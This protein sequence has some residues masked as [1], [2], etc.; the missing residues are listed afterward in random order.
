MMSIDERAEQ[1][2]NEYLEHYG[3]KGM[4]WGV[5]KK[6]RIPS[7]T[8][9]STE[10]TI[11]KIT[12]ND[13]KG[14]NEKKLK[15]ILESL[16]NS[17]VPSFIS[18]NIKKYA[19]DGYYISGKFVDGN[20]EFID[21]SGNVKY[22]QVGADKVNEIKEINK[23]ASESLVSKYDSQSKK[24]ETNRIPSFEGDSVID[25]IKK[26]AELPL[27]LWPEAI[28][29][30][31]LSHSDIN[32]LEDYI[33]HFG[34]L[35]MKWGVKHGPPY[36]LDIKTSKAIK[37]SG[38][39]TINV[40]DLTDEDLRRIINRLQMERQLKDLT[41]EDVKKAE[42]YA[43][44]SL[45]K[46]RDKMTD[47]VFDIAANSLKTITTYALNKKLKQDVGTSKKDKSK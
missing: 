14:S 24:D 15:S 44:K 29:K 19:K 17:D 43:E 18:D 39:V 42:S 3:V 12:S 5:R 4:R 36:P 33:E 41:R 7:A 23:K 25:K 37:K 46:L 13:F 9:S 10:D 40:K 34:I 2:V 45:K 1:K 22:L 20:I 28:K 6:V 8:I 32:D 11:K 16:K 30:A 35:G 47:T 21:S 26:I 38:K 31:S 27:S